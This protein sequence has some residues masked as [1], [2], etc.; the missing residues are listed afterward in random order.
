[1]DVDVY[2]YPNQAACQAGDAA[3]RGEA[4]TGV[5]EVVAVDLGGSAAWIIEVRGFV[6][7][8]CSEPYQLSLTSL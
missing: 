7:P 4:G 3:A 1:M 2:A 5:D 8:S 6:G